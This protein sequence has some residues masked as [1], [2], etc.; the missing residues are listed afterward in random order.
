[1][2]AEDV[3][4]APKYV[5][6]DNDV[7]YRPEFDKVFESSD[8]EVKRNPPASPNPRAHVERL[9]QTYQ[10]ECLDK[11]VVVSERHLNVINREFQHWYNHERPHSAR[12]FLPPACDSHP[13]PRDTIKSNDVVCETRLGGVLKSY[14]CWAA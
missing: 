9:I 5:L 3:E 4:L 14:R 1:M 2:H 13:E 11:F 8:A 12:D 6:R 10:L 7:K